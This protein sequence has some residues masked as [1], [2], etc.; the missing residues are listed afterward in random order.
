M[1]TF[2]SK[3]QLVI[4]LAHLGTSVA[5]IA[6]AGSVAIPTAALAQSNTST[7]RGHAAPGTEVVATEV[8]TGVVRRA[9]AGSNGNYV[10]TGLPAGNYHVT[11]GGQA[12]DLVVPVASEEVQDF[13]AAATTT[14][15]QI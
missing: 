13:A 12:V 14:R 6:V 4:R 8:A 15:T 3:R 11:A 5:A 9:T 7:L 2:S 10:V 1:T